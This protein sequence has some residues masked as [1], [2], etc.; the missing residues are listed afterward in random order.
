MP[1]D[2]ATKPNCAI[3]TGSPTFIKELSRV[4][5]PINGMTD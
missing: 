1:K 3:A 4:R 5:A 2:N